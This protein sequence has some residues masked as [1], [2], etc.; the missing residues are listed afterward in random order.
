MW[1]AKTGQM[2]RLIWVFAGRTLILLVLSCRGSF[3]ATASCYTSMSIHLWTTGQAD[4]SLRWAHPHFVDFVMSRL[5]SSCRIMLHFKVHSFVNNR[6]YNNPVVYSVHKIPRKCHLKL[7]YRVFL[8]N[9]QFSCVRSKLEA[10]SVYR[11][12]IV[13]DSQRPLNKVAIATQ[14]FALWMERDIH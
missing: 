7:Y 14:L 8:L 2:P 13:I 9:N 4:L 6:Q 5:I 3:H 1:T 12:A 10:V 11:S